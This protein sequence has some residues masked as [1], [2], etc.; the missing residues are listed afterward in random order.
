MNR[1]A[2]GRLL[3][4]LGLFVAPLG[5]VPE[6]MGELRLSGSLFVGVLGVLLFY[7]GYVLQHKQ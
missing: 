6:L 7:V 3:Q 5:I 2:I 4:I 1:R